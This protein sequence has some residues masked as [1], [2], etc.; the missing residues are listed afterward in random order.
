MARVTGFK[1]VRLVL[2]ILFVLCI[3]WAVSFGK[4]DNRKATEE[5]KLLSESIRI[6]SVYKVQEAIKNR[7]NVN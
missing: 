1:L 7:A 5:L 6:A 4:T 3:S 2:L